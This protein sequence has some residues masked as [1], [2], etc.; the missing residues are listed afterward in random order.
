MLKEKKV[1]VIVIAILLI[2]VVAMFGYYGYCHHMVGKFYKYIDADD[3]EGAITCVEKMPNV[4]MLDVSVPMYYIRGVFTQNALNQGYPLYYAIYKKA[5]ISVIE[6]LLEKGADPNR[7][8][9]FDSDLATPLHCLCGNPQKDMYEKVALLVEY[10][11]DIKEGYIYIP[12]SWE[13]MSETSKEEIFR[14]VVFLW[15]NGVDEWHAVGTKY[16]RSILH[17][18]AE[19]FELE[20]LEKMYKNQKRPMNELLDVQDAN[21]ETPLFYAVRAGKFDNCS[22]LISEGANTDMQNNEGKTV[23]DIAVELG[24]EEN[25]QGLIPDRE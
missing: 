16:E 20:Y 10:G 17:I 9:L 6:A 7:K 19:R 24:Y 18:A 11:A 14:T 8:E 22:F 12:A 23:Y 21:G 4:N 1:K 2:I 13:E 15:E 3:T 5:D 25:V